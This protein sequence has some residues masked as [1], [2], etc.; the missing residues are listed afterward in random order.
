[1]SEIHACSGKHTCPICP[2]PAGLEAAFTAS[3]A[4]LKKEGWVRDEEKLVFADPETGK[5]LSW[6]QAEDKAVMK[7][8]YRDGWFGV[9]VHTIHSRLKRALRMDPE[10]CFY[11]HPDHNKK[12][13]QFG[14]LMRCYVYGID[15]ATVTSLIAKRYATMPSLRDLTYI[16]GMWLKV[17]MWVEEGVANYQLLEIDDW[18][19]RDKN[20]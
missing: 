15:P 5:E 1:M 3:L 18:R 20:Q 4:F 14:D 2:D 8:I 7:A 10:F 13:Y 9:V 6:P 19:K 16:E 12:L 11:S 17:D